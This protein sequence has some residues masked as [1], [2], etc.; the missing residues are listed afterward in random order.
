MIKTLIKANK[1]LDIPK[2]VRIKTKPDET[3]NRKIL[4]RQNLRNLFNPIL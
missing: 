2:G 1:G 3:V 4:E